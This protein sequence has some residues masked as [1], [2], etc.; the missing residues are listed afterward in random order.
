VNRIGRFASGACVG[1]ALSSAGAAVA[2]A[3]ASSTSGGFCNETTN[4]VCCCT[5]FP[6]GSIQSCEC[7]PRP[8]AGN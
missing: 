8:V 5:T 2:P 3:A 6:D 7:Q 4:Y 1:V